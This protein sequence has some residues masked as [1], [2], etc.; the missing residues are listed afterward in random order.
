VVL[1]LI[2]AA[3]PA[4]GGHLPKFFDDDPIAKMPAPLPVGKPIRQKVSE[5]ANFLIQS[6]NPSPRPPV[7]AGG[8][9]TL[10]EV[11][12]SEWFT[13]RHGSRRLSRTELQQGPVFI[14]PPIP[15]FTVIG[16]KNEGVS[17]GFTMH[18][19][20]G[21]RYFMKSD[22]LD[23]AEL[24]TSA[25]VIV[26]KFLYAVGYN[27]PRNEILDLKLSDLRVSRKATI[28]FSDGGS[29]TMSWRDVEEIFRK[30]PS[31]SD[32]RFRLVASLALQ[33]EVIGP[34][35]YSGTRADD[36]NDI[37][38][39]ENRRDLRG[40]HVFSAWFNH[41][42]SKAGN[43]LDTIVEQNGVRFIRHHLIDFGSALG[44]DAV[45]AKDARLGHEYVLPG[46]I[47]AIKN[48]VT[49]GVLTKDWE[50][51]R[52]PDLPSV[53][54]FDSATFDPDSW[55]PSFPNPAFLSRLP[56]DDF[57]AAKQVMAF[58]DDDIRAIVETA[59]FSDPH[60]ARYIAKTL[61][62]RRDK[63]GRTFFSKLLPLDHFRVQNAALLF[64]DLA[65][66]FGF[67]NPRQ[68]EVRWHRFDNA[69]LTMKYISGNDSA[70]LPAEATASASGVYFAAVIKA[71][72]DPL[73]PVT[74]Y[75]RKDGTACCK[76][77]GIDRAW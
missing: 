49:L 77:V 38:L 6:M 20:R 4:I 26:S 54:R 60:A 25:E 24:S 53:G 5:G 16:G 59:G 44:S 58:T 12:D 68:F 56:D 37:V 65:V 47:D 3:W 43:T 70:K 74:V 72:G 30:F 32:G 50:R 10:G 13:N 9:N 75:L 39:H 11:P 61:A 14:E 22:P 31:R 45:D 18:D 1:A 46:P 52:F 71:V 48:A 73:K 19:A 57:W 63:I 66:R 27:T 62:E 28:T 42:D 41:T 35:L 21:R 7:A 15:P 64:D 2:A 29:R 69:S 55:K 17:P 67:H 36:P 76:V 51:A 40:L 33:G 34:F 8:V 23:H